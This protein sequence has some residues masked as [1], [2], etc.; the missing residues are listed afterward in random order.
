MGK[1]GQ[2]VHVEEEDEINVP[3]A[4]SVFRDGR[5][6]E[7]SS[8]PTRT[9]FPIRVGSLVAGPSYCVAV[10]AFRVE[11]ALSFL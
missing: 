7:A 10:L 1:Q 3:M 2:A 6:V 4:L 8:F 11:S 9:E 5:N